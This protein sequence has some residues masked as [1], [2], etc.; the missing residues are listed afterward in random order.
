MADKNL[1]ASLTEEERSDLRREA[2]QWLQKEREKLKLS[3]RDL[4]KLL[5]VQYYTFVSQIENGRGRIP[6]ERYQS[7]A[8]ALGMDPKEFVKEVLRYYEP[9]TYEILFDS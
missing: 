1:A 6:P 4:A 7:W 2:G 9:S 8:S 3:Q 5:D